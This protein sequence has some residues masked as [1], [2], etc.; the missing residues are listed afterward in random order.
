MGERTKLPGLSGEG[1][2]SATTLLVST[3]LEWMNRK[4]LEGLAVNTEALDLTILDTVTQKSRSLLR[5]PR[6]IEANETPRS[7]TTLDN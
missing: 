6:A 4:V 7:R 5:V 3:A 2:S 1:R